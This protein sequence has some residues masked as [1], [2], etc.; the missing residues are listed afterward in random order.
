MFRKVK[1]KLD[2]VRETKEENLRENRRA[3]VFSVNNQMRRESA[4]VHIYIAADEG[5]FATV[6]NL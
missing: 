2:R 5:A 3:C 6:R 1:T 4:H